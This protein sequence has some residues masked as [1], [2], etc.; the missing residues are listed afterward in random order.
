MVLAAVVAAGALVLLLLVRFA[1]VPVSIAPATHPEPS[2]PSTGLAR[3]TSEPDQPLPT[4]GQPATRELAVESPTTA[5]ATPWSAGT[6]EISVTGL[7]ATGARETVV[8]AVRW[9]THAAAGAELAGRL[10]LPPGKDRGILPLPRGA[11]ALRARSAGLASGP[12]RAEVG[13]GPSPVEVVLVA[14]ARL[15]GFVLD[16]AGEPVA[17]L[18]VHLADVSGQPVDSEV[19]LFDGAFEF[20]CAPPGPWSLSLGV[21]EGPLHGPLP[22]TVDPGGT[23]LGELRLPPLGMVEIQVH[24]ES[25]AAVPD[26]ELTGLGTR[27]ARLVLR[28]DYGGSATSGLALPGTWRFFGDDPTLGRGN[29]VLEVEADGRAQAT[30]TLRRKH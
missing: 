16:A 15:R 3:A 6:L 27:G 17:D 30:L 18:P 10:V 22:V 2:R 11:Y 9:R 4:P 8:E 14:C 29:A 5:G 24:D 23:M 28:T 26:L 13:E 20:A 21:F 7:P 1:S 25:G 19:T 12:V